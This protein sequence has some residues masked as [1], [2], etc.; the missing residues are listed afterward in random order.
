VAALTLEMEDFSV[1][2]MRQVK[3]IFCLALLFVCV[4]AFLFFPRHGQEKKRQEQIDVML[5]QGSILGGGFR[6]EATYSYFDQNGQVVTLTVA[7]R[8]PNLNIPTIHDDFTVIRNQLIEDVR[9]TAYRLNLTLPENFEEDI[10]IAT[11]LED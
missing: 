7:T 8:A 1:Y 5:E 3:L 10:R 9:Q 11:I 6:Y 2:H 4:F